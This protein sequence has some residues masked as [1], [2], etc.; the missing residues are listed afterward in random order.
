MC[1]K[2]MICLIVCAGFSALSYS[3]VEPNNYLIPGRAQL[4]NGSFAGVRSAYKTFDNG[5]NDGNCAQCSASRELKFFH[6][7]SKTAMLLVRSDGNSLDSLFE[8]AQKFGINI[9]GQYWAPYFEPD[10][11]LK[12]KKHFAI[13][14]KDCRSFFASSPSHHT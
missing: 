1:R 9:S 10:P 14:G 5:L 12:I 6:A 3:A 11:Y 2:V 4:F 13:D 8:F 7:L